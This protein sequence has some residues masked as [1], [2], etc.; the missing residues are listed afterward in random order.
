VLRTDS[1]S[2]T[3]GTESLSA[4]RAAGRWRALRPWLSAQVEERFAAVPTHTLASRTGLEGTGGDARGCAVP[5]VVV[6]GNR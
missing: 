1:C 3:S 6:V 2:P 5:L 4:S